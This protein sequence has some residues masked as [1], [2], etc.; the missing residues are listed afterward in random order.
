M[1]QFRG[2]DGG[3]DAGGDGG[4]SDADGDDADDKEPSLPL[5]RTAP[6]KGVTPVCKSPGLASRS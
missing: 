2:G 6:P 1:P 5:G 3:V 4:V